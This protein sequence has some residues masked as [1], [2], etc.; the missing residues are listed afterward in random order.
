VIVCV[1]GVVIEG[2]AFI[3]GS[4]TFVIWL[5]TLNV[6]REG[7][8]FGSPLPRLLVLSELQ[9]ELVLAK[10]VLLKAPTLVLAV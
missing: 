4:W 2:T 1:L 9:P 3:E 10:L 8:K 5:E 6:S 7:L